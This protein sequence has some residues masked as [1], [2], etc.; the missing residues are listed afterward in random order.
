MRHGYYLAYFDE[1]Y[2]DAEYAEGLRDIY[3][4]LGIPTPT[5]ENG[6][7]ESV[8]YN[9][10]SRYE[11]DGKVITVVCVRDFF[12]ENRGKLFHHVFTV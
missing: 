12:N 4:A 11:K 6:T 2:G 5:K 3:V 9:S 10:V 1:S 8:R 7:K